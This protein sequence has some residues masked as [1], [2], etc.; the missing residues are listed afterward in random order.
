MEFLST[1]GLVAESLKVHTTS[2]KT[3]HI[4]F[5]DDAASENEDTVDLRVLYI[6]D[7]YGVSDAFY[8]ELAMLFSE[9]PRSRAVKKARTDLNHTM[10]LTR[11]P[12]HEG[13]YRSFERSL[14]EQLSTMVSMNVLCT[15]ILILACMQQIAQDATSFQPNQKIKVR[16]S[17]DGAKF[18]R[19]SSFVLLSY[20][21]LMPVGRYLSGIGINLNVPVTQ[22]ETQ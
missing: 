17:G 7:R 21:I 8:H 15:C 14:C 2:G 22:P 13:A 6:L 11:I 4:P 12:G 1:Y 10:Q 19:T 5:S 16:I 20:A 18:S 3:F 9:L